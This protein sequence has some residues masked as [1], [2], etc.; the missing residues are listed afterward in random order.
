MP[1]P[2]AAVDAS[3]RFSVA[4]VSVKSVVKAEDPTENIAVRPNDV[5]TIP[6]A[7]M[8]YVIGA[9]H[10][11]GGLYANRT[12]RDKRTGSFVSCRGT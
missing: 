1:L 6:R 3:G 10:R 2:N 11:P 7:E 9:V 8:V 4:K 12:Q 5:I